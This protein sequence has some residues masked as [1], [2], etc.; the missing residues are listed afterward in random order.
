MTQPNTQLLV[1]G[2]P[3]SLGAAPGYGVLLRVT[4][5]EPTRSPQ[6]STS[7]N[8]SL[9]ETCSCSCCSGN[10]SVGTV[11]RSAPDGRFSLPRER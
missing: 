7:L 6:D 2:L 11:R 1:D 5:T 3:Q 4:F 10:L 8:S 9:G